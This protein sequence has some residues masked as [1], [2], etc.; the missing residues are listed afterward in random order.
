MPRFTECGSKLNVVGNSRVGHV[1]IEDVP[2]RGRSSRLP[3]GGTTDI[4]KND[5][6]KSLPRA[7]S[8][9]VLEPWNGE[10]RITRF[11]IN[12]RAEVIG[13]KSSPATLRPQSQRVK[14]FFRYLLAFF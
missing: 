10:L 12:E 7:F 13:V 3:Y 5:S 9:N 8:Q 4:V 11:A 2:V 1:K 14:T 6:K